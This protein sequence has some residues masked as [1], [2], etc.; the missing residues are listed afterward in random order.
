VSRDSI[1]I[2]VPLIWK[3]REI[4]FF[5]RA[6][7]KSYAQDNLGVK[8]VSAPSK[9]LSNCPIMSFAQE[10]KIISPTVQISSALVI[11]CPKERA[12]ERER[13]RER[14]SK[15]KSESESKN[16]S[17]N[18]SESKSKNESESKSKNESESK[19]KEKSESG[20]G[21]GKGKGKRARERERKYESAGDNISK[22]PG[23]K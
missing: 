16:E 5:L 2:N 22:P 7:L 8:K 19:S 14:E 23:P 17:K 1:T 10:K 9:N 3:V 18:E 12:R 6:K 15:S 4:I 20:K 13:E 21:T 11:L